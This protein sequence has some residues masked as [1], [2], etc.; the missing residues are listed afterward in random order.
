MSKIES[1]KG[2]IKTFLWLMKEELDSTDHKLP[3]IIFGIIGF[4]VAALF[5]YFIFN[6]FSLF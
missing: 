6:R 1:V 4:T 2:V 5:W 3:R